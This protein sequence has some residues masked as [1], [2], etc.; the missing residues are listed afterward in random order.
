MSWGNCGRKA[1]L[2]EH[3]D[4]TRAHRRRGARPEERGRPA[5]RDREEDTRRVARAST[6]TRLMFAVDDELETSPKHEA[7]DG[8]PPARRARAFEAWLRLGAASRKRGNDGRVDRPLLDR[9]LYRW[10]PAQREET[11]WDLVRVGLFEIIHPRSQQDPS[12]RPLVWQLSGFLSWNPSRDSSTD[13]RFERSRRHAAHVTPPVVPKEQRVPPVSA[14]QRFRILKRDSF[15][16][17]CGARGGP[18]VELHVDHIVPR[19][20]GGTNDDRNLQTLCGPCNL[21]KGST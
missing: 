2:L 19:C 16:C 5:A 9:I 14:S 10:F 3:V 12:D 1:R 13:R 17:R 7:L 15:T 21:G 4:P 8:L 11:M 18:S 6:E 20:R